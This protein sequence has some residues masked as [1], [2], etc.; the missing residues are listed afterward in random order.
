MIPSFEQRNTRQRVWTCLWE[1]ECVLVRVSA[2]VQDSASLREMVRKTKDQERESKESV[3][4]R[5][6]VRVKQRD[7]E[8][9]KERASQIISASCSCSNETVKKHI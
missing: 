6:K 8:N 7:S 3:L 2:S 1:R 4:E 5:E 9:K